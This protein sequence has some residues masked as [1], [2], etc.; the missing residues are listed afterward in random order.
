[1]L[2]AVLAAA[3]A[4]H[5]APA[6]AV[7]ADC[8]K[9]TDVADRVAVFE[10]RMRAWHHSARLQMRFRLQARTPGTRAWRRVAAPGFD[11]WQ[12]ADPGVRRFI[13]DKRVERLLAPASYRAVVRFRWLDAGGHTVGHA[14]R[15]SGVCR[16]PDPRPNLVVQ[17]LTVTRTAAGA[18]YV[19]LVKNTGRTSAGAFD[20]RFDAQAIPFADVGAG[21]LAA[22]ATARVVATGGACTP[23]APLSAIADPDGLIDEHSEA[24]NELDTPCAYTPPAARTRHLH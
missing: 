2:L 8:Q 5:P 21:P 7:V 9:S 14:K 18:R 17:S 22:G 11:Q 19:A 13:Y 20:V 12:S 23:G 24:D 6:R 16:E 10:G 1:M 3:A 4:V 15:T